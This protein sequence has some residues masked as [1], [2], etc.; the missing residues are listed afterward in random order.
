MGLS[1]QLGVSAVGLAPQNASSS[2]ITFG[3]GV[4]LCFFISY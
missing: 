4:A 2:A 3:A 1:Q